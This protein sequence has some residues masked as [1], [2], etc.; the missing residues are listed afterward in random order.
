MA[1]IKVNLRGK[2]PRV[3][4]LFRAF[5]NVLFPP[6][7]LQ[8]RKLLASPSTEAEPGR[9]RLADAL[10]RLQPYFCRQCLERVIPLEPPLCPCCGVMFRSRSG[11]DHL[12]GRCL[13]RPP[14]FG[15]A[16]TAFVYDRSLIDIIHCFKYKG[17]AQL[18]RPLGELLYQAFKL[19]WQ[20]EPV[21]VV[22]PVPMHRRRL[23]KRGFDQTLLLASE[24][25]KHFRDRHLP[26]ASEL[27]VRIR[28]T[29]SQT[30]LGLQAREANIHG[31]FGVRQP[32]KLA[33]LHLLLIDDVI[34]TG[35]TAAECARVLIDSG[36]RRVDVLAVARAL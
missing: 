8:C 9:S 16:R 11:D 25:R 33:G 18:A 34:T 3:R 1:G 27:L 21:D 26:V 2:L 14:P 19:F 29:R 20:S 35:A 28:E 12:C 24:C 5:E 10:Q 6:R 22:I 13:E 4:D 30:G 36:A 23:R 32:Q 7:C 17:K 15:K 31:A